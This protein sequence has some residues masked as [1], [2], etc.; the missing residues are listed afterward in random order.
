MSKDRKELVEIFERLSEITEIFEELVSCTLKTAGEREELEGRYWDV[1]K[2]LAKCEKERDEEDERRAREQA[3][4]D[5]DYF[6]KE[7]AEAR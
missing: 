5:K 2:K 4:Y 6:A 1:I 7:L 3:E